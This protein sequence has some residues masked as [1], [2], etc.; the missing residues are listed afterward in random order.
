MLNKRL[1]AITELIEPCEVLMDVGSDHGFLPLYLLLNKKIKH[2]IIGEINQGPLE[3]AK[4]NF[5]DYANLSVSYLLSDGLKQNNQ[6]LDAVVIAGMGYETIEHII[7][8]DIEQFKS[9]SQILIQSNTKNDQLRQFLNDNHFSIIDESIVKD[10]KYFYP[11]I[12]VKY[13]Q[14]KQL[15]NKSEILFGPILIQKNTD[16]FKDYLLFQKGIEEKILVAQKKE[17]S[18]KILMINKL[19]GL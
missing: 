2:A 13:D 5:R 18:E 8:Q 16:I 7:L 19:L 15:L 12:K 4:K 14:N 6:K 11:V 17:S 3:Q 1:K 10:R 9:I